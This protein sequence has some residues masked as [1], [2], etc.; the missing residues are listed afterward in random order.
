MKSDPQ[1]QNAKPT[2]EVHARPFDA[3]HEPWQTLR[4]SARSA[5]QAV[6]ILNRKGYEA[7][8]QTAMKVPN[9]SDTISIAK[10][11]P[12]ECVRCGYALAGLKLNR[13]SVTC[14]ECSYRQPLFV[15]RVDQSSKIDKNHPVIGIFAVIG[16]IAFIFFM[17][18]VVL[19]IIASL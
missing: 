7:A 15:W 19:I 16:M 5:I 18:V 2:W 8:V 1:T 10:L 11:Q 13:A 17:I 3:P 9:D 6:G 4:V 14:P 12:L